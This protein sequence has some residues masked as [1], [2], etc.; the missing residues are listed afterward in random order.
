MHGTPV[1]LHKWLQTSQQVEGR[2]SSLGHK[3]TEQIVT[4]F[5]RVI[6]SAISPRKPKL[7]AIAPVTRHGKWVKYHSRV[8]FSFFY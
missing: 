6:T 5:V 8:V 3:T 4:K 2:L 1:G 7:K